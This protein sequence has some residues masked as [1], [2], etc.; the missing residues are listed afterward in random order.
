MP[1]LYILFISKI[2]HFLNFHYIMILTLLI[3][4][5]IKMSN[6]INKHNLPNV[7]NGSNRRILI[8]TA[9]PY[10]NGS[11][12]LGH[13]LEHIQAD[14]WKRFQIANGNEC[15]FCCADDNHGTAVMLAAEKAGVTPET[16]IE[17]VKAEHIQDLTGF[18]IDYDNYYQTH[19]NENKQFS[20]TIFKI[21]YNKGLIK[22]QTIQQLF[23]LDK[24]MFLADR[25]V[26]GMCPH[27]HAPEQYGDN[28]EQCGAT[29]TA[30][31]LINQ[32]S[33]LSNSKPVIKETT[34][35]FFELTKCKT[36]LQEYIKSTSLQPEVVNKMNDWLNNLKDWCISRDEPYFGFEIPTSLTNKTTSNKKYFYVWLDAPIGYLASFKNLCNKG[37]LDFKQFFNSDLVELVSL[38]D[39]VGLK[40]SAS[41]SASLNQ[42]ELYHFIGKDIIQFHV[43]FWIAILHSVEF[44]LPTNIFAHG[45]VNVNKQK[46]SKSKGTFITAR[47]YLDSSLNPEYLRYYFASKL[48]NKIEDINFDWLDFQNK[49][50]TDLIG[51][52]INIASRT[53]KIIQKRLNNQIVIAVPN[54]KLSSQYIKTD[55]QSVN[56]ISSEFGL[57]DKLYSF[58]VSIQQYYE[59]LEYVKAINKVMELTDIV[60]QFIDEHQIW[61][62]GY[63]SD[64]EIIYLRKICSEIMIAFKIISVYL[65][66]VLP[67]TIKKVAAL[68]NL[69]M[70]S[71]SFNSILDFYP[72]NAD[73]QNS[74]DNVNIA[75][76][77]NIG[78]NGNN[79]Y[80][81]HTIN[82]YQHLMKRVVFASTN[83]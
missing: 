38:A 22:E 18:Y 47:E 12:H 21:L 17:K 7:P 4:I 31:D 64:D 51:K 49:I 77:D 58:N 70:C 81:M 60:N 75:N 63:E 14:I 42:T 34:H 8:T 11:I 74:L 44:R 41:T 72:I 69:D 67:E 15:Y 35:Y 33:T 5:Q 36:I 16:W 57:I 40:T 56:S 53:S 13:V 3:I 25:F 48:S 62:L 79:S 66:P 20:E 6:S 82:P 59:N 80:I 55:N 54:I 45:Y 52:Y 37:N 68:L 10:S 28:C 2:L 50:N 32:I 83:T 78:Y 23:D 43:L 76:I 24:H 26:K 1:I 39:P 9:L 71:F 61:K 19:S 65:S 46:M 30:I 29:Y 27:C 73:M